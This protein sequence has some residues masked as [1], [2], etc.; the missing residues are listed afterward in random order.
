MYSQLLM[1]AIVLAAPVPDKKDTDLIQ[2]KWSLVSFERGDESKPAEEIKKVKITF[3]GNILTI[4]DGDKDDKAT[5]KIDP[6]KKPKTIDITPEKEKDKVAGIYELKGD[7]LKICFGKPGEERPTK[8]GPKG[9]KGQTLI[10]LKRE[11]K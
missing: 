2:G 7:D 6:D 9:V 10:V 3:D 8:F 4:N 11:K 1:A 5:F